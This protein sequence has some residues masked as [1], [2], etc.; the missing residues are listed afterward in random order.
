MPDH[1]SPAHPPPSAPRPAGPSAPLS[2]RDAACVTLAAHAERFPDL[3]PP[4]QDLTDSA[5]ER[6]FARA[7]TDSAVRRWAVLTF[8][9]QRATK[10]PF[11]RLEPGVQGALL[12]GAAQL[13]LLDRV[14]THAAI[15]ETVEWVKRRV[16][17]RASGLVNAV[18]RRVSEAAGAE[19]EPRPVWTDQLDEIPLH[20]GRAR[21]LSGHVLPESETDRLGVLTSIPVGVI[22]R[23]TED[24]GWRTARTLAL[25]TITLPPLVL[26]AR[27]AEDRPQHQDLA[28][29]DDDGF[30]IYTGPTSGLGELVRAH[31]RVWVQD[32]GS[33][34]SLDIAHGLSPK[35]VFDVCAGRGTKTRQL[36][37]MF[38]DAE[39]IA[40][41][42]DEARLADLRAMIGQT[43]IEG[44]EVVPLDQLE[45]R[46]HADLVL[47]D[48]P[49]S[50]SGVLARRPEARHRLGRKQTRRLT[51]LQ[52]RL[53]SRGIDL[54][55]SG[56][57]VV[58]ATCSI[59]QK[60]N[61]SRARAAE[62]HLGVKLVATQ[63]TMPT[64][65]PGEPASSHRDG[66]F[67]ALLAK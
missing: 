34:R 45:S 13:V 3:L 25:Q 21:A 29:H 32:A 9:C 4:G 18:L 38:P 54:L 43:G 11:D 28:P 46:G 5:R 26:N 22:E 58:Y 37:A 48:V 41:D 40:T 1:P 7:I 14:P 27:H 2:G 30:F 57:H 55:R 24:F 31:E 65:L 66:G 12:A 64:G 6:G 42:S 47:L 23:W 36:R 15:N 52:D 20:D 63:R 33:A 16:R 39:I 59:E 62:T 10:G 67:A 35:R 44:V 53:L 49:C 8:L 17:A 60:E 50:N 56:G 51:K 61:E 19:E